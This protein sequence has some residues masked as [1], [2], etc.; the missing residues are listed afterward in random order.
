[1]RKIEI[2]MWN[3]AQHVHLILFSFVAWTYGL[4][5]GSKQ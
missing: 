3:A 5:S 4:L 2:L 1:M